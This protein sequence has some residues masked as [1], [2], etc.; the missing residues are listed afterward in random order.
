MPRSIFLCV[1]AIGLLTID[2]AAQER[3]LQDALLAQETKLIQAINTKDKAAIADLLAD[4]VMSITASRGRQTGSDIAAGLEEISFTDY[5]IS[6]SKTISVSP[7]VA[8]LTYKFSWTGGVT[9]QTQTTTTAYAT[10]V[11]RQRGGQW[12][13][14]FYQETP[15]VER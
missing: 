10:S 12:R 13:S 6:E 3:T 2:G 15:V 5:K 8:I 11:W 7:D 4:E 14:V 9:G 1:L